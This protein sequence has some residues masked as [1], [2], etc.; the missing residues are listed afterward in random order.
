VVAVMLAGP[1]VVLVWKSL[2]L[3]GAVY[4]VMPG[5][6]VPLGI[7]WLLARRPPEAVAQS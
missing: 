7:G 6:V 4:A 3:G 2:G 5:M 1:A